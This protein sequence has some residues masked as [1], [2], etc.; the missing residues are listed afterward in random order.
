M[1]YSQGSSLLG[2]PPTSSIGKIRT[3]SGYEYQLTP[4][5]LLWMGRAAQFEGG[6]SPEST[7]WTLTQ[8]QAQIK[9]PSLISLVRA[10]SQPINPI[11]QTPGEGK[12]VQYPDRCTASNI[13][14]RLVARTTSWDDLRP[15]IREK[16][17]AWS[18]AEL[19]NP[20]P[21]AVEFADANVSQGFILRNPGTRVVAREKNWYLATPA[22][23]A[24][25]ADFV[26]M[27]FAGRVMGPSV[28]GWMRA[29]PYVGASFVAIAAGIAFWS[30][31]R[32]AR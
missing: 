6:S 8:R 24:W 1:S 3:K 30:W 9:K 18:K 4:D 11:W 27:S 15:D 14:R 23:L 32:Q 31:K 5:D 25:P 2:L 12:C 10:Y 20:V 16:V 19:P 17:L 13:A 22:A 28:R 7:I 21:R 26:T 29:A